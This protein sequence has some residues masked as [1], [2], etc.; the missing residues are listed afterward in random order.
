MKPYHILLSMFLIGGCGEPAVEPP[1]PEDAGADASKDAEPECLG[2]TGIPPANAACLVAVCVLG[3]WEVS[4]LPKGTLC[5][6]DPDASLHGEC[7]GRG[8]CSWT[9]YGADPCG[10][11]PPVP[12][13]QPCRNGQG[14]CVNGVCVPWYPPDYDGGP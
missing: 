4:A 11:Q 10:G 8:V 1:P 3:T 14:N 7:T 5:G 6:G 2:D 12:N 13:E 9:T